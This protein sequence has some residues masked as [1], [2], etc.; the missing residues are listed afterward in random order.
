M[1]AHK[2][3]H[4]V[5]FRKFRS[6][7]DKSFWDRIICRRKFSVEWQAE[8]FYK[9]LFLA[10]DFSCKSFT[11]SSADFSDGR[12]VLAKLFNKFIF[13]KL[14]NFQT[15]KLVNW[16]TF[17]CRQKNS[18]LHFSFGS[19]KTLCTE[20]FTRSYCSSKLSTSTFSA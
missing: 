11:Q 14:S 1:F 19:T 8:K 13:P 20:N 7:D 6:S 9:V 16:K 18:S 17:T 10:L 4:V 3:S 5:V 15:F 12:R 2:L